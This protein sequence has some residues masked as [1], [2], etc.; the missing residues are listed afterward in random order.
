MPGRAE[1]PRSGKELARRVSALARELG[2]T[3]KPEFKLG[4]RLWGAT[5]RIDIILRD[6]KSGK[7]LGVECKAQA[8]SGTTEE[9][10]PTTIQDMKAWPIAGLLV[11]DG[12]GFTENMKSFLISTGQAV[13][14]E[15]LESWLRLYFGLSIDEPEN[16]K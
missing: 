1:A 2:L 4:R 3:T 5:R 10:I 11:F 12:R 9:K 13:A 16:R 15:D 14:F 7:T 8:K 6:P